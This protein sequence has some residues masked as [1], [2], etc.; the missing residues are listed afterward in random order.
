MNSMNQ[1]S[2]F[3]TQPSRPSPGILSRID[4]AEFG[5][6]V[7]MLL[8]IMFLWSTVLVYPL[9]VLVVFFHELS[10]GLAAILTGG[11]IVEIAMVA[12]E[13]GHCVTAGGNNFI[14]TSAGYL[15]SL[16]W[17]AA[18]LITA[19]RTKYDRQILTGLGVLMI[20]VAVIYVR[21]LMGFGFVFSA[22]SGAAMI[23][24]ARLLGGRVSDI[25]LRLIG[26]TSCMY[27]VLDIKSDVLD[28]PELKSDA[29]HLSQTVGLPVWFWGFLWIAIAIAGAV[30]ALIVASRGEASGERE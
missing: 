16:V 11:S 28:R 27:V 6:M 24:V 26:L 1:N 12:E 29:W 14:I 17:G 21:P 9:K 30:A 8:V 3:P 15:G 4:W 13:G 22:V 25:L 5:G 7:G 23:V 18:I 10:H 19:S 20:A 2:A